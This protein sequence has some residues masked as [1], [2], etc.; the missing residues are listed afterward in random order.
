MLYCIV[1]SALTCKLVY[2]YGDHM[3]LQREPHGATLWGYTDSG[4]SVNVTFK[5]VNHTSKGIPIPG[6]VQVIDRFQ[7]IDF[8]FFTVLYQLF[9]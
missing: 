6:I 4:L 3:V 2:I 8:Q 1:I 5:G 9:Y 7:M